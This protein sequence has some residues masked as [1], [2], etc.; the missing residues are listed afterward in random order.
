M[1]AMP[2]PQ[3]HLSNKA[4]IFSTVAFD[5]SSSPNSFM[6]LISSHTTRLHRAPQAV[7]AAGSLRVESS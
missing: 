1:V 2:T 3:H 5:R 6:R 7:L 4:G